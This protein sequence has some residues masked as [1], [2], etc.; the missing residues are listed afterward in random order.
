MAA[1]TGITEL[2]ML[3]AFL[4][5][6]GLP[7]GLPPEPEKPAMAHVAPAECLFYAS[8][9]G[10]AAANP[11]SKNHTEQ[12]LAEPELQ[13]FARSLE[14]ALNLAIRRNASD[15]RD[16]KTDQ[17]AKLAPLWARN[18]VTRSTAIFL[19]D[20]Q[21]SE[22]GL[23][24]RGGMIV[25]A[26]DQSTLLVDSLVKILSTEGRQPQPISLGKIRG[27]R[28]EA[29]QEG[30]PGDLSLATAGPYV[31][32]SIG[33]GSLE[34]M[35]D[36]IAAKQQPAWLADLNE[37]LPLERRASLSYINTP[38]LI[39]KFLP[40]GGPDG[41]QIGK[42]LGL[43]ELGEII[44][45]SGLDD[46][47]I[48]S[49]SLMKIDA[50]PAGL[51]SLVDGA[52]LEAK[53]LAFVPSDSTLATAM[54]LDTEQVYDL[55]HRIVL[56]NVPN[57]EEQFEEFNRNFER[58]ANF[59][60][61]EDIL[62]SLGSVWTLSASP[63]DGWS[64]MT[65]TVEVRDPK[66]L[67]AILRRVAGILS[68]SPNPARLETIKFGEYEIQTLTS[69]NM[70]IRPAW[71]IT[72]SRLIIGLNAQAVKGAVGLAKSEQGLFDKPEFA[73]AFA[74]EGKV[75]GIT[76]QDTPKLFEA[77]YSYLPLALPFVMQ[78]VNGPFN[79]NEVRP[80]IWNPSYLPSA[81]SIHR[82]LLPSL[83]VT[84]RTKDGLETESHSTLPTPNI[85]TTAP[86]A[87]ALLLPA[88]QAAQEAS[89]RT[90]SSNNL[91]Q[92]LL[93]LHN[94]HDTFRTLPPAYTFDRVNKKPGL[95]WR[96]MILPFIEEQALYNQ[97]HMDE[98]WD[99][100]NNK[101][102]IAKM[103]KIYR[104]PR[105]TAGEG[106]TVYLGVSGEG[107]IFSPPKPTGQDSPSARGI[108]FGS[109]TDGLSNTIAVVEA[110][111]DSA[112][113]WT[114]PDDFIPDKDNP[115]QGLLGKS[116]MGV[117]VGL[118]DGSVRFISPKIAPEM[119][120]RLFGRNDGQ[121]VDFNPPADDTRAPVRPR[122]RARPAPF[123]PR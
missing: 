44:A 7:L 113:I 46:E 73:N 5:G 108:G 9:S 21:M 69:P 118:M 110:S 1:G 42:A 65:A 11:E 2:A 84:R 121:V 60:I 59:R 77:V 4:G 49:R 83:S 94:Y 51:L 17:L 28:F 80:E 68:D 16:P 53:D 33:E 67:G 100:E 52:G 30:L 112:V 90:Q 107:G 47:G 116:S 6:F 61:K 76:Y 20:V 40:L 37:R 29:K 87:V 63:V 54:S 48:V 114:K 62:A 50:K 41:E 109:V 120:L 58:F 72:E 15:P 64:G 103:P 82:H 96:V 31:L 45:V 71:C 92:I 35:V 99:S 97:F 39:R 25:D 27:H 119:L 22:Q 55:I 88:V 93:A 79:P 43:G 66:T 89:R 122:E 81:R 56:E 105:S 26:G 14:R 115:F 13:Q 98:P 8:W 117:Q 106:K 70:P 18:V 86:V 3:L 12:L 85:G 101:A 75:I 123:P 36:R 95:S 74:G 78:G 102:L 23:Q 19:E 104:S 57:G 111:D 34:A 38:E 32:V 10:M 91:K 24:L